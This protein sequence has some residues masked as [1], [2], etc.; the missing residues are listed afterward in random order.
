MIVRKSAAEL[1]PGDLLVNDR[2]GGRYGRR[3]LRDGPL[4]VE[5]VR[6]GEAVD[7]MG[8][9]ETKPA[10]FYRLR[11]RSGKVADTELWLFLRN[12]VEVEVPD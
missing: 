8:S 5:S 11:L 10:I 9:M 1:A 6:R 7:V 2:V 3:L 12:E 4:R